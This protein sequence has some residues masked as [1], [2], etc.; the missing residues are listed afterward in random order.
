M[1]LGSSQLRVESAGVREEQGDARVEER[2]ADEQR[3]RELGTLTLLEEGLGQA[4][5]ELQLLADRWQ[6]LV[7]LL[8]R[9]SGAHARYSRCA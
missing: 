7:E 9:G 2:Q 5:E 8:L 6:P 3:Q 1:S 4:S